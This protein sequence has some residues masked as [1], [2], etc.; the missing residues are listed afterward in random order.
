MVWK[1][2]WIDEDVKE[3]EITLSYNQYEFVRF[4]DEFYR[5]FVGQITS[6]L[7]LFHFGRA[8]NQ[9][10]TMINNKGLKSVGLSFFVCANVLGIPLTRLFYSYER[11]YNMK[12]FKGEMNGR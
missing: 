1:K 3:V 11:C 12:K 2:E 6:L 7:E 5:K 4:S 9:M 10:V 8:T